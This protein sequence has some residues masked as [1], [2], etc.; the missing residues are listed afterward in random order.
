MGLRLLGRYTALASGDSET[1]VAYN[2]YY[3]KAEALY[4]DVRKVKGES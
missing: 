4:S 2:Y 3:R 1:N